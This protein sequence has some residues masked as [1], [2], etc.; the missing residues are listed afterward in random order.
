MLC[1]IS[2]DLDGDGLVCSKDL[3]NFATFNNQE[4][5]LIN[6]DVYRIFQYMLQYQNSA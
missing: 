1:F 6:H 2:L 5:C 3:F 4:N